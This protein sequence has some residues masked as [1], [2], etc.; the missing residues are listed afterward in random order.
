[1]LDYTIQHTKNYIIML[2]VTLSW[3]KVWASTEQKKKLY[4]L[5]GQFRAKQNIDLIAGQLPHWGSMI[6]MVDIVFYSVET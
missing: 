6:L 3:C 5:E 4:V 1:M 2:H